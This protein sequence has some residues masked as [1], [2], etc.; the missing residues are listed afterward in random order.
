MARE[1]ILGGSA[2][3]IDD[4]EDHSLRPQ[5]LDEMIGQRDVFER[6]MIAVDAARKR[7]DALGH[8]LFDGPPGLGKTT[9][10]SCCAA[11]LDPALRVVVAEEVFECDVPLPNVELGACKV[12]VDMVGGTTSATSVTVGVVGSARRPGRPSALRPRWVAVSGRID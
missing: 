9:M 4:E 3:P 11:E 1:T 8:I 5:R 12:R 7:G 2:A 10:L 6:L